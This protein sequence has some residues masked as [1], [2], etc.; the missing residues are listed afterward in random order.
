MPSDSQIGPH[1]RK[2]EQL[3]SSICLL[4]YA[5]M[6]APLQRLER[7]KEGHGSC[8]GS[9]R[10]YHMV[11]RCAEGLTEVRDRRAV[12][13]GYGYSWLSSPTLSPHPLLAIACGYPHTLWWLNPLF[14]AHP[15]LIY[16]KVLAP[17]A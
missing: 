1:P 4:P 3:P 12:L 14:S 9:H 10:V 8:L 13:C 5:A 2:C 11:S 15:L 16:H 17:D 7:V 6:Q